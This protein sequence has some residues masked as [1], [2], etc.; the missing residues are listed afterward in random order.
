MGI[1]APLFHHCSF[2]FRPTCLCWPRWSTGSGLPGLPWALGALR[3][4]GLGCTDL[5][6]HPDTK[7]VIT[8]GATIAR[9]CPNRPLFAA[10][11]Q[12]C[13]LTDWLHGVLEDNPEVPIL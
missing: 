13:A 2:A 1:P 4:D 11:K 3:P 10:E 6:A 12:P 5:T 8:P 9:M 7:V